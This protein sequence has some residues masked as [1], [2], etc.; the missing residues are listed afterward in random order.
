MRLVK[1]RIA[2]LHG[3]VDIAVDRDLRVAGAQGRDLLEEPAQTL[4]VG[5]IV[6]RDDDDAAAARA[7]RLGN[8]RDRS[9]A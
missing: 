9:S 6:A 8:G 1:R 4:V 3:A 7:R 5:V 2:P